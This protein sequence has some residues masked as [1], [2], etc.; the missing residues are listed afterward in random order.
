[1]G[2]VMGV[3]AVIL[4]IAA[5]LI[6]LVLWT[7]LLFPRPAERAARCLERQPIR[8]FGVGLA[9]T[10]LVGGPALA[11]VSAPSGL[12]KL[13]GWGL[14]L[15]W[16]AVLIVGW[17]GMA[18]LLGE[19]LRKLAPAISPLGGL[20]RGVVTVE[21]GVLPPFLGWFVFA[22]L[23]GVTLV[24]AGALGCLA[25]RQ[26]STP[27]HGAGE[28]R[29]GRRVPARSAGV[30][31]GGGRAPGEEFPECLGLDR[32]SLA[33]GVGVPTGDLPSEPAPCLG[34]SVLNSKIGDQI[35]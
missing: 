23:V 9:L 33:I 6:G 2:V 11:L 26:G 12:T 30:D 34:A 31:S 24:G 25:D 8:C 15:P 3:T 20:V 28:P 29:L 22:P 35:C 7:A 16:V 13:A 5:G 14:A 10:L 21:L 32:D 19:R 18:G 1:M 27:R 4:G 17:A